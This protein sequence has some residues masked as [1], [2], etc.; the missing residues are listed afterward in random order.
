MLGKTWSREIGYRPERGSLTK[1]ETLRKLFGIFVFGSAVLC[2][3]IAGCGGSG[4]GSS[5]IDKASFVDQ[6]N[7]ICERASGKMAAGVR[8]IGQR[9]AAKPGYDVEK[10]QIDVTTT[11]LVPGLEEE[12]QSIR[13]LGIPSD[14]KKDAQAFVGAFQK[15]IDGATA[16]PLATGEGSYRPFEGV[17]LAA[18]KLGIS[19]CPVTS[20]EVS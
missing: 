9:E 2:L 3:A 1:G 5:E 8:S 10:T 14:A 16:K 6:A 15:G 4:N 7:R 19:G 17:E 20:I 13:S 18:R 12:L 11:V